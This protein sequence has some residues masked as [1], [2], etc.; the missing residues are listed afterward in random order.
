M[1]KNSIPPNPLSE[2]EER[3]GNRKSIQAL[4]PLE[5]NFTLLP[6]ELFDKWLPKFRSLAEMKVV[7]YIARHTYGFH[8]LFDC[9]SLNQFRH[10]VTRPDGTKLDN[11]T[12]LKEDHIIRGLRQAEEDGFIL[13]YRFGPPGKEQK[14][15]FINCEESKGLLQ[16]LKEGVIEPEAL[17]KGMKLEQLVK[18]YPGI[19]RSQYL[20]KSPYL[21][22]DNPG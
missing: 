11:G 1:T 10:G 21:E 6:N 4:P 8:K 5:A 19:V 13:S 15:Y 22:D 17:L 2:Q 14:L 20:T 3:D 12:G 18:K 7:F 9:L 16:L